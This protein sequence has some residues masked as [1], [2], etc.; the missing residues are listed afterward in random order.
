MLFTDFTVIKAGEYF[1]RLFLE[2]GIFEHQCIQNQQKEFWSCF[3][4]IPEHFELQNFL[5][6]I[7]QK[8]I[9]VF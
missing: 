3:W 9:V 6:R 1:Y 4:R 2:Q 7:Y 5:G 8:V